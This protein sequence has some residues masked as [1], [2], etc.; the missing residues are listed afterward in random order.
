MC[1][2]QAHQSLRL[3][4]QRRATTG[5]V[6]ADELVRPVAATALLLCD[7]WDQH[8]CR[9]AAERLDRLIPAMQRL[10]EVARAAGLLIIHAPSDTMAFY[11]DA[12]ARRRALALP[13]VEPPLPRDHADP[14]LPIDATDGGCDTEGDRTARPWTRQHPGITIADSDLIA[15][16]GATVYSALDQQ[17]ITTLVILG[18]HT[19]MCVLHRSFAIKQMTRWG[20]E[21]LL[22]RDLTDAM[23]NPARPPYVSHEQG[24]ALVIAHIEQHW[25][26]SV[27]SS[28]LIAGLMTPAV[29]PVARP[30][31]LV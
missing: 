10:V 6:I 16:D 30:P 14:P 27:L 19:N 26:P 25:C 3:P 28:D 5:E 21:C 18:V 4:V 12:P 20:V 9:G 29:I 8:W 22:V 1:A 7:V 31:H 2:N 15:D 23:Y 13:R 17:G 11:T 24:T